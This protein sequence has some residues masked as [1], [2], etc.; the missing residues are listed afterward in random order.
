MNTP[1]NP[2]LGPQDQDSPKPDP[3]T[4]SGNPHDP[5]DDYQLY[6]DEE[7]VKSDK[8]VHRNTMILFGV[9]VLAVAAIYLFGLRTQPGDPSAQEQELQD[10]LELALA[11]LAVRSQN[12]ANPDSADD[13]VQ[14]F[15]DYPGHQQLTLEELVRNPFIRFAEAPN[16]PVEDTGPSY[17][18]CQQRLAQ[19]QL[20]SVMHSDKG[21]S[22]LIDNEVYTP[23]QQLDIFTIQSINQ[24]SVVFA[25][26]NYQFM[27]GL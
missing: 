27:M 7:F 1:F 19:H 12:D 9:C 2:L 14:L 23:G 6:A 25:A 11:K 3:D 18:Q 22:C 26:H 16:E 17:Q 10:Q 24:D 20:Q 4:S 8:S 13:M 15:Y 21:S 5:A